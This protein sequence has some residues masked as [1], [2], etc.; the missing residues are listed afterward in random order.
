MSAPH[1][2]ILQIRPGHDLHLRATQ[3]SH[4]GRRVPHQTP[5]ALLR[6][7]NHPERKN[8]TIS[9]FLTVSV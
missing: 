9:L 3:S 4:P 7:D 1:P 8:A 5:F 6:L 2:R